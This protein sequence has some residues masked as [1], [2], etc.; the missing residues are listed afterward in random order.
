MQS[1][2]SVTREWPTRFDAAATETN[3]VERWKASN[4]GAAPLRGEGPKYSISM[5]PPNVTGQLHMGH[6]LNMTIQDVLTRTK[7]KQGY[8]VLWLPGTDHASIAVHYVIERDLAKDGET[9][10]S[11]GRERFLE[12]CEE[13]KELASGS[14]QSQLRRLGA[15]PDWQREC[16]TMD[17]GLT[18]A[19]MK[20]FVRLYREGLA[21]RGYRLVNWDPKFQTAISD[22]EVETKEI[23]GNLW[24]LRYP[25]VDDPSRHIVVATTR[26]E[27][28]FG[29]Q[30][31][32]VSAKDPRYRDLIGTMVQLP[33]TGR[34]IP[35][36]ADEHA[37]PEQG[38]GAV[39]ITPAHD[40]N[41]YEV[42]LRHDLEPIDVMTAD[43]RMNDLVPEV[44]RGLDRFD[45]RKAVIAALEAGGFLAKV[46][47]KIVPTPFGDRSGAVIEPRLTV[48]W[49]VDV[50]EM[51]RRASEAVRDD[52]TSFVPERWAQVF[53][54]W[55][56][57]IRPWCVSRQLWY[58]H[59]IPAWYGPDNEIFVEEDEAA[60]QAAARA[61]YGRHHVE[62]RQ[63]SDIFDTWFSSGLWPFATLGWPDETTDLKRYYPTNVLVTGFDIIFFWVARMMMLGLHLTDEAPFSTVFIHGL[64]RD[65]QGQKMSKT[66]GNVVDPIAL[67]DEFGADATRLAL[68]SQCGPGQ[69]IRFSNDAVRAAQLFITKLWNSAR[70]ADL[71]EAEYDPAFEPIAAC[72]PINRWIVR[73]LARAGERFLT[74]ID[75]YRFDDACS[76]LQA[77]VRDRFS[78]WY[79]EL[80]KIDLDGERADI[81]REIRKTM[82]WC[83]ANICHL[84]NPLIPFVTEA[85]WGHLGA[86]ESII[87]AKFPDYRG[88]AAAS[89][90][91]EKVE[92]VIGLVSRIRSARDQFNVPRSAGLRLTL[93]GEALAIDDTLQGYAAHLERL[94]G[95]SEIKQADALAPGS[96]PVT[97]AGIEAAIDLDGIVD[98]DQEV[99]R[100][101]DKL[102]KLNTD[103]S[104]LDARLSN[105][106]FISR[107]APEAVEKTR[108]QRDAT[109][110]EI[111]RLSEALSLVG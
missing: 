41:D 95:I 78:D 84:L 25:L 7:R 67:I 29:D 87:T 52:K 16:Y 101:A 92:Q 63:E 86:T 100:L 5:P 65:A 76:D 39:K 60:A 28:M 111:K 56:D 89:D 42:G 99:R 46:E 108:N 107:A 36:I 70:F 30:A 93:I 97:A 24:H 102:E 66:K 2:E 58:G 38:S 61:H 81:H 83:V 20:V 43:A 57:N 105:D 9:R 80:A 4:A 82:G 90:G 11:I 12:L 110:Q 74:D 48:Q 88:I 23:S 14:I 34:T 45:A 68:M 98:L 104:K 55:M 59:R 54:Q 35:I 40:F 103:L 8:D 22:L 6:A 19:V 3:L 27:T 73:D 109:M 10:F 13:W 106:R 85:I 96:I 77:F 32:A 91:E 64:V 49:F 33:L 75:R 44:F 50:A 18:K 71:K 15:I 62:L 1:V 79:I 51:A 17:P 37:D 21:Y 47:P 72:H 94:A 69:D 31:V 26:P 53:F